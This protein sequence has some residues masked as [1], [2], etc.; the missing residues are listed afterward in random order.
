[1]PGG[2]LQ[3]PAVLLTAQRRPDAY[4]G[5]GSCLCLWRIAQHQLSADK[6]G[7]FSVEGEGPAGLCS[8]GRKGAWR[9]DQAALNLIHGQRWPPRSHS[10]A[11]THCGAHAASDRAL[12]D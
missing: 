5:S 11:M 9:S 6:P 8:V 4:S 7:L 1:M 2:L 3:P 12:P 10:I